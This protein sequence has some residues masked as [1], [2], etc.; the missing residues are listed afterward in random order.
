MSVLL[1]HLPPERLSNELIERIQAL[2]PT[3][4]IVTS[5]DRAT[6]EGL[7]DEIEIS[8]GGFPR[9]LLTKAKRL[10]WVQEWGAGVDWLLQYPEVAQLDLTITNTAGMHG[11]Q[12]GEQVMAYLLAFARG[13]PEAYRA[14]AQREWRPMKHHEVFELEGRT[15]LL[16]GLGAIGQRTAML[17]KAFGM[18]VFGMR[19]NPEI[20]LPNIDAMY[21]PE[22]LL[23]VLPQVDVVVL[24]PPLN[25]ETQ[26]MIGEAELRAMKPTAYLINVGRG[27]L[28]QQDV[29]IRAL[30]EG[31]IAGAGLDVFTPEPLPADSE[32]WDLK[33]VIITAHYGGVTPVYNQRASE[34]FLDNL[35]R[36][37][38]GQPLH[39]VV[40]KAKGY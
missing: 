33:N 4:Q 38:S 28:V 5:T 11:I 18:Q 22:Q 24:S 35:A 8:V 7:L 14:Q 26:G 16:I 37:M 20:G 6:I 19:R 31:W 27:G 23:E 36:Y 1:V 40:D 15:M 13:L 34:I 32:L 2:A 39:H 12:I 9:D 21:K 3:M 30:R 10:R 25:H 29:L 17:A